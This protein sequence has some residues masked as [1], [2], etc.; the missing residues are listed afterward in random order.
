MTLVIK[1]KIV[2]ICGKT[3]FLKLKFME[4][5]GEKKY[6]FSGNRIKTFLSGHTDATGLVSRY[7]RLIAVTNKIT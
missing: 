2:F 3:F 6:V 7:D 1:R 5:G 4:L